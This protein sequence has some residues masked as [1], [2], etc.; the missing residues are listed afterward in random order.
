MALDGL[1]LRRPYHFASTENGG[2]KSRTI[3]EVPLEWCLQVQRTTAEPWRIIIIV[4]SCSL[5]Q[6]F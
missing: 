1:L 4:P 2:D 3:D 5:N 6:H